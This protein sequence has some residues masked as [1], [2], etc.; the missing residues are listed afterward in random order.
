MSMVEVGKLHL[1]LLLYLRY[2]LTRM[3]IELLL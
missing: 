2:L 3:E 1:P